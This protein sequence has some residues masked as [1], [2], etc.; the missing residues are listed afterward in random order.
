MKRVVLNRKII[1]RYF[2]YIWYST[3]V[4][5]LL[6]HRINFQLQYE[7]IFGLWMLSFDNDIVN[8]M[9]E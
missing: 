1:I 3:S 2:Y 4:L 9:K 8:E 6:D 7:L 5:D